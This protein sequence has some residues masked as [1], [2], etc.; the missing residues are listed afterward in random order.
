MQ[1]VYF[2]GTT[3]EPRAGEV[4]GEVYRFISREEFE[5]LE[6]NGELLESGIFE[7]KVLGLELIRL[8]IR[9]MT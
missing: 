2:T 3:R 1:R 6:R 8:A 9:I 4:D 5:A 7:G